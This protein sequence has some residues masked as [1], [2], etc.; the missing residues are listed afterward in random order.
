MPHIPGLLQIITLTWLHAEMLVLCL[1]IF[2]HIKTISKIA[3]DGAF[4]LF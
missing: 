3:D 4:Y 1:V 2:I